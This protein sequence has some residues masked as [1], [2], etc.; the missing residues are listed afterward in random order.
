[1]NNKSKTVW[2]L[3]I[4]ML[5]GIVVYYS[6][7]ETLQRQ[8]KGGKPPMLR[9]VDRFRSDGHKGQQVEL[10]ASEDILSLVGYFYAG[11]EVEALA[12]CR[13]IQAMRKKFPENIK[14]Q[15]IGFSMDPE[16]DN[17]EALAQFATKHGFT[18]DEWVF[19]SG[20]R[21]RVRNYMN[22]F[23]RYP[24][25]KKPDKY[26]ESSTDLYARELRVSLVFKGSGD[27]KAVIR[28]VY[29]DGVRKGEVRN[30]KASGKDMEFIIQNEMLKEQLK[31]NE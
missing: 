18:S 6:W 14:F 9:P 11:D 3:I 4:I 29:W 17:P 30:D 28:G 19:V 16:L 7:L 21:E 31:K 23:F 8:S 27:E 20:D 2:A 25:H 26:R 15:L 24:G 5:L 13:R 1:M 10:F 12:V 22:K